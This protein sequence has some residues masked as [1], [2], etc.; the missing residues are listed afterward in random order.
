MTTLIFLP[1]LLFLIVV[2]VMLA[3]PG[4]VVVP[5]AMLAL[6]AIAVA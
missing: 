4:S 5:I 2:P 1:G 6:L 3:M